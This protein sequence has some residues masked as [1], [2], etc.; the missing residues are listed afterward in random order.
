[1]IG[2][3]YR[4]RHRTK[5]ELEPRQRGLE[6]LADI[7]ESKK[8]TYFLADGTLLG[9]VREKDFIPWDDDVGLW[10]RAEEFQPSH[11][12]LAKSLE[13]RGFE[14]FRGHRRNPKLNIFKYGEKFELTAWKKKG[15][16]RTRWGLKVP[17]YL[18]EEVDQIE[19]RGRSYPCPRPPEEF[20]EHRYGTDWQTPKV[21][22][23]THAPASKTMWS[24]FKKILRKV[25][26]LWLVRT[27][28]PE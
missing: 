16:W 26:P 12:S 1:M 6:E 20:L 27:L 19:L 3:D 10:M 5:A 25:S 15:K 8:I 28:R 4:F 22:R 13:A 17:G 7:L 21:G 23:G 11:S 14:V 24:R 18:L 2:D 9:A